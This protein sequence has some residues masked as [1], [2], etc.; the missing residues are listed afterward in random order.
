MANGTAD[1]TMG[2]LQADMDNV[3]GDIKTIKKDLRGLRS[4]KFSTVGFAAGVSATVTTAMMLLF[5]FI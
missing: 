1:Y 4:W 3:K 5:K 2:H